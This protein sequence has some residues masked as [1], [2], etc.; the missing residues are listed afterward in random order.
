MSEMIEI[1]YDDLRD[2]AIALNEFETSLGAMVLTDALETMLNGKA[3]P[4]AQLSR[5]LKEDKKAQSILQQ[6]DHK[7]DGELAFNWH[8]TRMAKDVQKIGSKKVM[9]F[10][11]QSAEEMGADKG[12]DAM[13]LAKA[14]KL[15][16]IQA[17]SGAFDRQSLAK[18]FGPLELDRESGKKIQDEKQARIRAA[19]LSALAKLT[20]EMR[21]KI[22]S[23]SAMAPLPKRTRWTLAKIWGW[24]FKPYAILLPSPDGNSAAPAS[25]QPV[26]NSEL[27]FNLHHVECLDDTD[28]GEMGADE[29][30]LGGASTSG[31]ENA[32]AGA[33]VAVF[34]P[35]SAGSYRTGDSQNFTP[36]YI[37][38][39]W[40]LSN[41]QFP[42]TFIVNLLMSERDANDKFANILEDF[43]DAASADMAALITAVSVAAGTAIGAAIGTALGT[44]IA[45]LIG[46]IIGAVLGALIGLLGAWISGAVN[47]EVFENVRSMAVIL[48][49]PDHFRDGSTSTPA[50]TVTFLDHGGHYQVRC[51]F[52]LH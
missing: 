16:D 39:N 25:S 34:G 48:D 49:T 12:R 14:A 46:S 32:P 37:L 3:K 17:D 13:L 23:W 1:K 10:L 21:F 40:G 52:S 50:E 28:G 31:M 36:H 8:K 35:M 4:A 41:L 7:F 24:K 42:H 45:P 51:N 19:A 5:I 27:R 20:P 43:A 2:A 38:D 6:S 26:P 47:P 22:R 29:I 11:K 15:I 33:S 30:E 44:S 9:Q 18:L